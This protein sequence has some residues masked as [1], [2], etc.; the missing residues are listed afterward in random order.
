MDRW[1]NAE[2]LALKREGELLSSNLRIYREASG[3]SLSQVETLFGINQQSLQ[4]YE[5]RRP[6][7]TSFA[8]GAARRVLECY[9]VYIA[10]E[11]ESSCD[12]ASLELVGDHTRLAST[13]CEYAQDQRDLVRCVAD[14]L[15][16]L[17]ER[18]VAVLRLRYFEGL[19]LAEVGSVFKVTAERIRQIEAKALRKLRH[20]SRSKRLEI[21]VNPSAET[22]DENELRERKELAEGDERQVLDAIDKGLF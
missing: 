21:F 7:R 18:E 2:S 10:K 5:G 4:L 8:V 15:A 13:G 16:S 9:K 1:N 17:K 22:L 20:S 6:P 11:L 19:T 12:T 14:V 3:L